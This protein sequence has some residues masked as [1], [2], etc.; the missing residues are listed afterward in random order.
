MNIVVHGGHDRTAAEAVQKEVE[1][2]GRE[3][4]IVLLDLSATDRLGK[5]AEG[6][7]QRRP[8]DIWVNNAGA[9]VLTGA[10]A[11]LS[12]DKKFETVWKTDVAA[13]L[14]LSREIGSRMR[15][16]GSGCIINIGWDQAELGMEGDSGEMFAAS[17]GAI[18]CASRSL[19][20]SFAPEVRVNCVAPGWIKTAWGEEASDYWQSRAEKEALLN[21]WG[22]PDDVAAAVAFLASE[23]A[24]FITGQTLKVNG[25][26]RSSAFQG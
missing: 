23:K 12:F 17:K 24:S 26:F 5:F 14:L 15:E 11:D 22:T 16:R 25:G 1:Q 10:D 4:D 21:R 19:A 8:I 3:T 13:T 7:W 2:L 18:M 6:L 20:K 9:D